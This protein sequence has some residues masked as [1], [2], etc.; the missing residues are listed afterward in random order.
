[1]N[2]RGP[3]GERRDDRRSDSR[4]P[5]D[6]R[7]D[8][9]RPSRDNR[10]TDNR[11]PRHD[12][13]RGEDRDSRRDDRRMN[14]HGSRGDRRDD[15]R[16]NDRGPR[17]DRR[18]DRRA[19]RSDREGDRGSRP[20]RRFDDKGRDAK[21]ARSFDR[22]PASD[23]RKPPRRP[24]RPFS[25]EGAEEE[26]REFFPEFF[27]SCQAGM[28]DALAR[29]LKTFGIQK[30]RPLGGGVTFFTD[31]E[32]AYK[33]LLWSRLSSRVHL[34]LDRVFSKD[35][36]ELYANVRQMPWHRILAEDATIAVFV[37]GTNA[38]LRN[39]LYTSQRIK[40][41]ICDKVRQVR[42]ERPN[43][44]SKNPDAVISVRLFREKATVSFDLAGDSLYNRSYITQR[45]QS[46]T[47]DVGFANML[48][49]SVNWRTLGYRR[50][51]RLIDPV[52]NNPMLAVEAAT[53][54]ADRAPG[55]TR[56][57]WG[58]T[59]WAE[60]DADLWNRLLDEADERFENGLKDAAGLG[61]L[62][63]GITRHQ[64]VANQGAQYLKAAGVE[65]LGQIIAVDGDAAIPATDRAMRAV[66]RAAE[67]YRKQAE[68][69][70]TEDKP[71][72]RQAALVATNLSPAHDV[73]VAYNA[74]ST[75]LF[76][77]ACEQA[78]EGSLFAEVGTD[79]A[80][81][82]GHAPSQEERVGGKRIESPLLIFT[83][84]PVPRHL[85][86]V[87][88]LED[89]IEHQVPVY[90]EGSDQFAARLRKIAKER[91]KWAQTMGISCYR[92]YDADLLDY[93][94][95]IDRYE[96][97]NGNA[98]LSI[99]EYA[100]PATV[101][102]DRARRRFEDVLS[103]APVVLGI[104]PNDVFT[105]TR[106]QEKGGGQ[107]RDSGS[108]SRV[109]MVKEGGYTFEVD[110]GG[111]LDTGLFLDHRLIRHMIQDQADGKRFLNLFAYTGSAT[112]YAAGGGARSTVTVDMS[113]N[114]LQ[115]AE[116]NLENNG[117]AGRSYRFEC[118]D[119]TAWIGDARR[120]H[121]IFDLIFVD[122]PTFSN[123]KQMGSRTWD[124]Q[125][126]HF[127][128]LVGVVHLLESNGLCIFSCNLKSFKPDEWRLA[129]FGIHIEDISERTIP[130]DFE[131]RMNI[132]KCYLVR[133]MSAEEREETIARLEAERKAEEAEAEAAA[134][135]QAAAQV[136]ET[137]AAETDVLP[138]GT[139]QEASEMPAEPIE[140]PKD[141]ASKSA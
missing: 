103:I 137:P 30:T 54:V 81:M 104:S 84:P 61:A 99:A 17:G 19:G 117:Y 46:V 56:S 16:F 106:R 114:Y 94:V 36:D 39:T 21:G 77:R 31:L 72:V 1:M 60:H 92:I 44:D 140:D 20:S 113:G 120:K 55:L 122:P 38:E 127:E 66:N 34:V 108:E 109:I 22:R 51:Y 14:D 52:C 110:L 135:E 8:D 118:E 76:M 101:D 80:A 97:V 25:T 132:H 134:E 136:T 53:V 42:G 123:S 86:P 88:G 73:D 91:R 100:P 121:R 139:V 67:S 40:D 78:P 27:A 130:Q 47:V 33:A 112:V 4:A 63:L 29:E 18:D 3:R 12:D 128:L 96:D 69:A 83:K 2:D 90:E 13:R 26:E 58:F 125:R 57:T 10:G 37:S 85:I 89:G 48:L 107:Y 124:V 105:K 133:H 65:G 45:G 50:H 5:R 7:R 64:I 116:R 119:V 95:A 9:R 75:E 59:G 68:A 32:H 74:L 70:G 71:V 24:D 111:R 79:L 102:P 11:G 49:E 87:I 43:V 35:G 23:D 138:A 93:M 126:D 62:T 6:G 98:Y 129:H 115:W 141:P 28:E 82:Y 131:R 15:R 41:A